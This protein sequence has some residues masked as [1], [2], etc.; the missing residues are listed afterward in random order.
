MIDFD[1]LHR[2]L[3]RAPEE[4]LFALADALPR[5]AI[6]TPNEVASFVAQVA[7]ES[8]EFT[9]LEENLNYSAERMMQVWPRKFPTVAVTTPYVR[10]PVKLANYVYASRMGNGDEASGDGFR[11][12]GRGPIQ[13]TGRDNYQRCAAA[14]G[15][16]LLEEPELLVAPEPGIASALWFWVT[17]G[18]DA[19]DDDTDVTA[20]TKLVNG[21][22][23]GLAQRQKY[24]DLALKALS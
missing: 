8:A 14:T 4:W 10:N 7:H 16:P 19:H 21:G 6:D 24:F 18:L 11:F 20:E 9:R 17:R 1:A 3:P 22:T 15:Y 23:H 12:R 13:L 2:I 5:S